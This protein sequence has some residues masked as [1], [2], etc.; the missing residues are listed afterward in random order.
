MMKKELLPPTVVGGAIN[1]MDFSSESRSVKMGKL[2]IFK[3][4]KH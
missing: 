2:I 4:Q 3:I 1:G